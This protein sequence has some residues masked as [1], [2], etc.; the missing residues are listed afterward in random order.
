MTAKKTEDA[1]PKKFSSIVITDGDGKEYTLRYPRELVRSMDKKGISVQAATEHLADA[2]LSGAEEFIGAFVAPAFK[3]DQPDMTLDEIT[4][5]VESVP[6]KN[7]FFKAVTE[8]FNQPLMALISDP[9]E[10]RMKW[11]LV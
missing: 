1:L 6:D 9:T 11:S 10:T 2:T 4:E 7:E 8:L 5:I 3:T